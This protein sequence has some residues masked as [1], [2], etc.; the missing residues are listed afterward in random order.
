[1]AC[2][3][4]ARAGFV[5]QAAVQIPDPTTGVLQTPVAGA[6]TGIT[7]RLSAT[8]GGPALDPTVD[9]LPATERSGE[10]GLFFVVVSAALH[11]AQVLP[12]GVGESFWAVW[13]LPGDFDGITAEYTIADH[14]VI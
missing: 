12:L 7:L 6:V 13:K 5:Y 11:V 10:P 8:Q 1:M 3:L 4:N 2:A 14:E 9:N